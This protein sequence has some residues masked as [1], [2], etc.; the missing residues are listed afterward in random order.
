V[1]INSGNSLFSIEDT[2]DDLAKRT[3]HQRRISWRVQ[4]FV[5]TLIPSIGVNL[6]AKRN[7]E[8]FR[9]LL[10][11]KT[12]NPIVLMVGSGEGGKGL[13]ELLRNP[14]FTFIDTDVYFSSRVSVVADAHDLPFQDGSFDAIICQAVLEH[15][16]N[17]QRCV[18]EIHRV[19][20]DDG[21]VYAETPFMQ[22]V[23]LGAYD[24]NR[25][26]MLGHRYLFRNFEHEASGVCCGP[27]MALAWSISY[28]F[29]SFF[30]SRLSEVAV[31]WI[32]PFFIFWLKYLD[33]FLLRRPASS[34]AA[35]GL[36]FLGRKAAAAIPDR[37]IIRMYWRRQ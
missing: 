26:T 33:Y 20:K 27:G 37:E 32:I 17:P 36:Y 18:S 14:A 13:A 24:F 30:T 3:E 23:H 19:L 35:S 31:R 15:V 22:Q 10:I 16:L 28:F 1:L 25:F 6:M 21:I 11:D 34:D 5:S 2:I 9:Q 7:Y 29:R 8:R 12:P 4:R